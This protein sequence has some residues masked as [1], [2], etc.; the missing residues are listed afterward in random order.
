M[1]IF[2]LEDDK[3]FS[4]LI[5]TKYVDKRR[6]EVD[7]WACMCGAVERIR[8]E[9]Y[10]LLLVDLGLPETIETSGMK[11][12]DGGLQ[13]LEQLVQVM[14]II[15]PT[16]FLTVHN[17]TDNYDTR[18]RALELMNLGPDV[19]AY[20]SKDPSDLERLPKTIDRVREKL[21]RARASGG[22]P[23]SVSP[24]FRGDIQ[25]SVTVTEARSSFTLRDNAVMNAEARLTPIHLSTLVKPVYD[26][27]S[28]VVRWEWKGHDQ[29]AKGSY[30]SRINIPTV[31][32][33]IALAKL[34]K[35]GFT[36]YQHIFHKSGL[37]SPIGQLGTLLRRSAQG[38]RLRIRIDTPSFFIPWSFLYVADRFDPQNVDPAMFLGFKHIVEELLPADRAVATNSSIHSRGPMNVGLYV[39]EDIGKQSGWRIVED[40]TDFWVGVQ[41]KYGVPCTV[42]KT[43]KDLI[44]DLSTPGLESQFLY[45]YCHAE[46]KSCYDGGGTDASALLLSNGTSVTLG[47]LITDTDL[48]K[49]ELTGAPLVFINA[50]DTGKLSP[51]YY[52][53]WVPY[54]MAKGAR[55]IMGTLCPVPA[56]FASEWA[57]RFFK[58]FLAGEPIGQAVLSLRREFLERHHNVLGLIYSLYCNADTRVAPPLDDVRN[59]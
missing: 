13:V 19:L 6:D 26:A 5:A 12:E 14:D 49:S 25:I 11:R 18:I 32:N 56:L 53:G 8:N 7:T 3:I 39:N 30:R 16:I 50:C 23:G 34:A 15:P 41:A 59:L 57:M 2:L 58:R 51:L 31:I 38:K 43:D 46:T 4:T 29:S 48:H 9:G 54:F 37:G 44:R 17:L 24:Y 10:D 33:Q 1:R 35:V 27:L 55:G 52:D 45:L 36:L 22:L 20:T 28:E 42:G 47:G 40:Q 21:E